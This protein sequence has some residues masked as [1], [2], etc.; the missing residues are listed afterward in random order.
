MDALK[1]K[2]IVVN[3]INKFQKIPTEQLFKDLNEFI[4][5]KTIDD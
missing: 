3:N 2:F 1:N 5:S 4:N